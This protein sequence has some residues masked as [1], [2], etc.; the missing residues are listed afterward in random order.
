MR[1]NRICPLPVC[2]QFNLCGCIFLGDQAGEL[3]FKI[4]HKR[5][6]CNENCKQ[7]DKLFRHFEGL[8]NPKL[9]L[10]S[11]LQK[12]MNSTNGIGAIAAPMRV[13]MPFKIPYRILFGI[14]RLQVK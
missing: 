8:G 11:F 12:V 10:L 7:Q 4:L 1:V 13:E 5:L 3:L 14:G 9:Q 2:K 6:H